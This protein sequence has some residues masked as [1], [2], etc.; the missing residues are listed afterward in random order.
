MFTPNRKSMP[1]L[2]RSIGESLTKA[3]RNS[4]MFADWVEINGPYVGF[5]GRSTSIHP[6]MND[7][8]YEYRYEQRG[9]EYTLRCW[10]HGIQSHTRGA[11]YNRP[12]WLNSILATAKVA[13]AIPKIKEPPPDI[14][15]WFRT[16]KDHNLIEF[17][18]M[19]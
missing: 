18:E 10:H 19:K 4:Q 13:G 12:E 8:L 15:L 2:R 16:D 7:D 14:I 6:P 3:S 11:D 1:S 9:D 5:I 17:V